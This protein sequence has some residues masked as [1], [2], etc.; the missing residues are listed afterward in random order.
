MNIIKKH[1]SLL[2]KVS[3]SILFLLLILTYAFNY[4]IRKISNLL[5]LSFILA[6]ILKPLKRY[7]SR[8]TNINEK[9]ISLIII[10][11]ILMIIILS[12][13]VL[14]PIVF[15]EINNIGPMINKLTDSIEDS[16]LNSNVGGVTFL[17][18]LYDEFSE[19]VGGF[20]NS[21]SGSIVE[22]IITFSENILSF[23]VV[24]V[25]TYYFLAD[26]EMIFNKFYLMIP[27]KKRQLVKKI[28]KDINKLLENYI[29]GQ[30]LLSL[31]IGVITFIAL[32]IF[33]VKFP[34]GLSI[35][36]GIFNIIPYFG[37]IFGA[38]PTVF[39]ALLDT[40]TKGIC[41]AVSIL[42]IQQIE[43]NILSPKI[44]GDC[45][46]M[47]PLVVIILLLIGETFGG[48]IG[49]IIAIPIGVIV[50]VIYEDINYYIF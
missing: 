9:I 23:A 40:P 38:V 25:I 43:G 41:I 21:F 34:I 45:T 28:M 39:V 49:M 37:P 31:I 44:T 29:A 11:V 47:H 3:I 30:L 46:N 15:K 7:L 24:P 18:F 32:L 42:I 14:I 13:I 8:I 27:I 10:L 6:Y 50:K 4:N 16:L 1:K 22:Y 20:I 5:I 48:F 33:K 2:V 36:N 12:I 19:R 17:R 35:L 26:D